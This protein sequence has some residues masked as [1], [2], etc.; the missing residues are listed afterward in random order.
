[1]PRPIIR[2][3]NTRL[4][5]ETILT[6]ADACE[7]YGNKLNKGDL[8]KAYD[9]AGNNHNNFEQT[10]IVLNSKDA[11]QAA[12]TYKKLH[13]RNNQQEKDTNNLP[14]QQSTSQAA[15]LADATAKTT[16]KRPAEDTDNSTPRKTQKINI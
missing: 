10:Y 5:S 1:M 4:R 12:R 16:K 8:K 7:R 11:V 15:K 3:V 13:K 14:P 2:L 9:L 6:F